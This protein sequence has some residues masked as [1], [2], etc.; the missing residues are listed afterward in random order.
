MAFSLFSWATICTNNFRTFS[1]PPPQNPVPLAATLNPPTLPPTISL[2]P[3]FT[4]LSIWA[5]PA[6]GNTI[7]CCRAM[8]KFGSRADLL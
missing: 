2:P 7:S 5:V 1:L 4:D 8:R 6:T 3:D